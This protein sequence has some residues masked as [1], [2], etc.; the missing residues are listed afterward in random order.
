MAIKAHR[1]QEN[2]GN[3]RFIKAID[4]TAFAIFM[5]EIDTHLSASRMHRKR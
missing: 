5:Y 4:V 2:A 1:P 3:Y